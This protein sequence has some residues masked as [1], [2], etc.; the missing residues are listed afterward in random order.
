MAESRRGGIQ[1]P[2]HAEASKLGGAN[3][4][5]KSVLGS[6]VAVAAVAISSPSVAQVVSFNIPSQN[7]PAA[8]SAFA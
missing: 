6:G 3:M 8:I 2:N 1:T 7:L 4:N 5:M